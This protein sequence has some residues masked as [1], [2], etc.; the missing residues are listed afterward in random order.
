MMTAVPPARYA[1]V[2][3]KD[4]VETHRLIDHQA[5]AEVIVAPARG[6]MVTRFRVSDD[7]ILF[8]DQATLRDHSQNVRG[9]IPV[10]FPIAGRLTNDQFVVDGQPIT[11]AQHGFARK[12]PWRITATEA[13]DA[14][15]I[16]LV[17]EH[18]ESTLQVWPFRFKLTFRYELRDGALTIQQRYENLGARP[19]PIQPG[20][21]PYFRVDEW[22]KREVH[23]V[24]AANHAFDN[25]TGVAVSPVGPID[26]GAG[27]VDL[28]LLDHAQP[29]VTLVRPTGGAIDL[30]YDD[31]ATVIVVWTLPARGFVCVEPW[32]RRADA[33]NRG[34]AL[35]VPVGGSHETF[36]T[37]LRRP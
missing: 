22:R 4:L 14:A 3:T 13:T 5:D 10:L 32:L 29:A 34:D 28:Q 16:T 31:P 19:M 35:V 6:G 36:L 25:R 2:E 30:R 11:M 24:T 8:L 1:V 12:I 18:S 7:D 9:G 21:H 17:L 26:F 27:E 23:V 37:I 20:L 15:A 33:L